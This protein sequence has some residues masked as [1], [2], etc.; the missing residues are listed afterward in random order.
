MKLDKLLA[1]RDEFFPAEQEFIDDAA[2]KRDSGDDLTDFEFRKVS[3][4]YD[5][6]TDRPS[7]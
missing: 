1:H 3:R 5:Q 4:M 6:I 7:A 2:E